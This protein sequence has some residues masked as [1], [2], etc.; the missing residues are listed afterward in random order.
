MVSTQ[1]TNARDTKQSE[2]RRLIKEIEQEKGTKWDHPEDEEILLTRSILSLYDLA[3]ADLSTEEIVANLKGRKDGWTCRRVM[4]AFVST[5]NH[6][7]GVD[8]KIRSAIEVHQKTNCLTES[9][10]F[11]LTTHSRDER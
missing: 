10:S 11:S 3:G 4:E 9:R 7:R 2:Q 1:T 5:H 8:E 6:G